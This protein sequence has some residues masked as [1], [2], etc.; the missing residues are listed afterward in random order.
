MVMEASLE[1][2]ALRAEPE[3]EEEEKAAVEPTEATRAAIESFM[4]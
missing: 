1:T 2:P 3:K 4:M